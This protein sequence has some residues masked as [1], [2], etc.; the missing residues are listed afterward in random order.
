MS[1]VITAQII[2]RA[3]STAKKIDIPKG[4]IKITVDHYKKGFYLEEATRYIGLRLNEY[5]GEDKKEGKLLNTISTFL[6]KNITDIYLTPA[7]KIVYEVENK[8]KEKEIALVMEVYLQN[9]NLLQILKE[10]K[11]GVVNIKKGDLLYNEYNL[12]TLLEPVSQTTIHLIEEREKALIEKEKELEKKKREIDKRLADLE[13]IER[14]KESKIAMHGVNQFF[15]DNKE[16]TLFSEENIDSFSRATGLNLT[17]RPTY[18]GVV[19]NQAQERVMFGLLKAFSD[20][21]YK[22]DEL[23][24]K[25]KALREVYSGTTASKETLVTKENAPY[26]NIDA[27]PIVKLTQ[28]KLIELSGYDLTKQRQGDKQDVI[29][30]LNYL[31]TEQFCFYWLR[32]KK[33]NKGAI[34]KDK[35][36]DYLKEE[37]MEVGTLFRVKY[38]KEEGTD[39]LDYYEISPTAPLLDQVNNY[40]LLVPNNWREEVKQITGNRASNYT[41]K[42]LL[43]LRREY[44][45]IRKYNKYGGK[46]RK[47]RAF[48]INISWEEMAVALKMPPSMYKRNRPTTIKIIRKAYFVAME[49]GYLVKVEDNGATDILYL[50]EEYYPKPGELV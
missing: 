3:L 50:N 31:G 25:A 44:E 26:K 41:Y 8:K 2:E 46:A 24:D 4:M 12:E 17:N 45:E 27:I 28:A 9:K 11:K 30:A 47:P 7:G 16:L 5:K 19:L 13:K 33:D 36:G 42:L 34:V 22:G 39:R 21:N 10:I 18:Y 29:E 6:K 48:K 40:F 32:S 14:S 43:W 38:I 23:Q 1:K 49:L 15:G 20:T 37:V 35:N